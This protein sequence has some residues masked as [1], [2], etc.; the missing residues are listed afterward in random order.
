[1]VDPSP[2]ELGAAP[3]LF[4][5]VPTEKSGGVG[6]RLHPTSPYGYGPH[7]GMLNLRVA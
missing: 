3:A 5:G 1:M 2:S 7:F 6:R 4:L